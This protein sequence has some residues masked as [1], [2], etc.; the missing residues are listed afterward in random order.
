MSALT[1]IF[2]QECPTCG[3][4]LRIPVKYFGR[5]MSCSHCNGE[6]VADPNTLRSAD[7]HDPTA[8]V[9]IVANVPTSGRIV[10]HPLPQS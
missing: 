2:Y 10:A 5:A 1:T 3:R 4:S 7:V 6:F 8:S 9:R